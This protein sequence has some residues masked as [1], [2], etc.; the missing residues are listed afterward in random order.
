MPQLMAQALRK[1]KKPECISALA[2][3]AHVFAARASG[4]TLLPLSA[5]Y[6]AIAKESQTTWP[7]S[8]R[9]G[10]SPVGLKFLN[11]SQLEPLGKG[12]MISSNGM[13]S[14]DINSHGRKDH[15]E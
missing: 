9:H 7:L 1:L 2:Q 11:V 6:S 4:Q 10:T 15:E 12:L 8:S 5:K 13:E 14:S 3:R